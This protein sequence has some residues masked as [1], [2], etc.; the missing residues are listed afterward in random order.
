MCRFWRRLLLWCVLLRSL[1]LLPTNSAWAYRTRRCPWRWEFPP[2]RCSRVESKI[3][4]IATCNLRRQFARSL[5]KYPAFACVIFWKTIVTLWTCAGAR[6]AAEFAS[7]SCFSQQTKPNKYLEFIF[8][9]TTS[10]TLSLQ[11]LS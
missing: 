3:R 4:T 2:R 8:L 10:T 6:G 11:I 9:V 1:M 7:S 5:F